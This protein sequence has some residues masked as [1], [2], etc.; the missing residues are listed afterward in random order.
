M[1]SWL[2]HVQLYSTILCHT[3]HYTILCHTWHYSL[4]YS[5]I[6]DTIVYHTLPYLTLH[7]T[8]LC[9]TDTLLYHTLPY[10]TLHSTILCHT[11]TL[12]YHT[13]PYLTLHSTILCHT[14]TT[15]YHTLPYLTLYSTILCHT[16]T[17][18]WVP[19][20]PSSLSRGYTQSPMVLSAIV[21]MT[22]IWRS[23][24]ALVQPTRT[25]PSGG[26]ESPYVDTPPYFPGLHHLQYS[27][28]SSLWRRGRSLQWCQ[29]ASGRQK[30]DTEWG[31]GVPDEGSRGPYNAAGSWNIHFTAHCSIG[32]HNFDQLWRHTAP[33]V[34]TWYYRISLTTTKSSIIPPLYL[35]TGSDQIPAAKAWE[36]GCAMYLLQLSV[37]STVLSVMQIWVTAAKNGLRTGVFFWP[38]SEVPIQGGGF[39]L[40]LWVLSLYPPFPPPPPPQPS[41]FSSPFFLLLLLFLLLLHLS[42]LLF[43]LPSPSSFSF[44]SPLL[45]SLP[46]LSSLHSFCLM[47]FFSPYLS[48]FNVGILPTYYFNYSRLVLQTCDLMYIMSS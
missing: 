1:L 7:S 9:H 35:H 37:H 44:S 11:D 34:S 26:W 25:T 5:A 3:W 21:S 4:P 15:L 22:E 19:A 13:L 2:H 29:V 43:L 24:F 32:S 48:F 46:P 47:H 12:L 16:D 27:I 40:V 6:L 30:I 38:G 33:C 42:S 28:A 8:I 36:W 23:I 10:L 39:K 45:F 20:P 14:D 41:F 31:V 17:I 18:P